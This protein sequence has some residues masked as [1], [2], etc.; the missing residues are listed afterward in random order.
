MSDQALR[1]AIF[2]D[3]HGFS[4]ALDRVLADIERH[5]VDHRICAGDLVEGGP[6]PLGVLARLHAERIVTVQGNTDYDIAKQHRDSKLAVWCERQIGPEGREYLRDLPFDHRITPPGADSPWQDLLVVHANP[7]D[8][9]R[10]ILPD[11]DQ[12]ELD[13]IIGK[14]R[15]AVLAFGHLHTAYIRELQRMTLLDVSAVGNPKDGDLRSKWGLASWEPDSL[16]WNVE[17]HYVDYPLEETVHQMRESGM[18]NVE[19]HIAKLKRASYE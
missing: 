11:A 15:A 12:S 3:I 18:P 1:I 6:D 19:K 16:S 10:A 7:Y 14:T 17:L 8:F 2:S 4:L 5:E 13:E 9:N